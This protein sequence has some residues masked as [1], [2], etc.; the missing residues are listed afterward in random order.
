MT[1][2]TVE[3]FRWIG[4]V[5]LTKELIASFKEYDRKMGNEFFNI[6]TFL[7]LYAIAC[8]VFGAICCMRFM[9]NEFFWYLKMRLLEPQEEYKIY[10]LRDCPYSIKALKMLDEHN[11]IYNVIYVREDMK[12]EDFKTKF[13]QSATFPRIYKNGKFLGGSDSLHFK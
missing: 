13:G 11:K 4:F 6:D 7:Y 8:V 10:V 1:I 3:D 2:Y 5:N 12:Y 9:V